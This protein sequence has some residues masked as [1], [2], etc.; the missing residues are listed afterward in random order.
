MTRPRLVYLCN[1]ID[2]I[3]CRERGINSDSPAATQK[4]IQIASALAEAG[5]QPIILSLGRGRQYGSW[6]WHPAHVRRTGRQV[7]LYAPFLDAPLLTHV[8]TMIC[9]LPLVWRLKRKASDGIAMLAYNWLPHYLLALELGRKLGYRLFLDLEDGHVPSMPSIRGRLARAAG[10]RI[11]VLCKDG[12]ILATSSLE[13]Q[14]PESRTMCCYGVAGLPGP[15]RPWSGK[16]RVLLGGTLQQDTGAG[17]FI[18]A[19]AELRRREDPALADLEFIVTGKGAMAQAIEALETAGVHPQVQ[20]KGRLSRQA[21]L[22]MLDGVHVGLSLKL[23]SS[24]LGDTTFPSKV[25]E[26]ASAGLLLLTTRVSDVPQLFSEDEAVYLTSETYL[27]LA[28]AIHWLL[29]NREQAAAMAKRG[30]D[31]VQDVCAQSHVGRDF[32]NF[33]F[34]N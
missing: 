6:R 17:L 25:I 30:A 1:A 7:V 27:E 32:R 34:P 31:R 19:V 9:L 26:I 3:T 11:N 5:V 16:L 15:V 2:E 28:D 12:A 24:E 21:Y 23:G 22:E 33:L 14:Y 8:V 10:K 18:D 13:T 20:F 4:V 29:G